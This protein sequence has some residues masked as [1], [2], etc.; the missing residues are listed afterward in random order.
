[1][2]TTEAYSLECWRCR[3]EIE[4]PCN[5]KPECPHCHAPLRIEWSGDENNQRKSR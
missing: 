2:R 3:A 5:A 4:V 1:M